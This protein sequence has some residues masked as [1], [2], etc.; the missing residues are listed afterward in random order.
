MIMNACSSAHL[1]FSDEPTFELVRE[2]A[3]PGVEV[4]VEGI[5]VEICHPGHVEIRKPEVG[6]NILD[7]A[8]RSIRELSTTYYVIMVGEDKLGNHLKSFLEK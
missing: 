8:Q 2:G 1:R 4:V 3:S 5:S 6:I 7:D